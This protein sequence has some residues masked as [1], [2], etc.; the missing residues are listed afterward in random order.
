MVAR[1]AAPKLVPLAPPPPPPAPVQIAPLPAPLPVPQFRQPD[2]IALA[3]RTIADNTD[4]VARIH[5]LIVDRMGDKKVFIT[6]VLSR[7][8]KGRI[9]SL[10]T[11]EQ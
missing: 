4:E 10:R 2:Q 9:K 8:E 1:V 11:A 5:A 3:M 6:D 7:D